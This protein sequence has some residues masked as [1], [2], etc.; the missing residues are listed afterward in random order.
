MLYSSYCTV[1]VT[2]LTRSLP[3][4]VFPGYD[5]DLRLSV[6]NLKNSSLLTADCQVFDAGDLLPRNASPS[7]FLLARL[8][9][10]CSYGE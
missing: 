10:V 4:N 2:Q 7:F 6:V 1:Q 8:G 3:G 5:D 9:K